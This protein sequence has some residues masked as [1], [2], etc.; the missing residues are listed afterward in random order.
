M[1]TLISLLVVLLA[2]C[3]GGAAESPNA[4][5]MALGKPVLLVPNPSY[6]ETTDAGDAAQLTDGRFTENPIWFKKSSVG[7]VY[8]FPRAV[9]DLGKIEPIQSIAAYAAGG[10]KAGVKFPAEITFYVSDDNRSFHEVARL[11]PAGLKEDGRTAVTH[12]FS[13]ENLKTRGRYVLVSAKANGSMVFWDEIE[14]RRGAFDPREANFT[15]VVQDR[16]T[17]VFEGLEMRKD[18][19]TRGHFP[20]TPH[21][22]WSIPLAGGSVKAI[23]MNFADGMRDVVE[24]A[25][26]LDL[27][28]TPVPHWS[29]YRPSPLQSLAVERITKAL[30]DS[31]VMVVG[32]VRWQDFPEELLQKIKMRVR[33]GMGLVCVS[34]GND[35][36]LN[37]IR[38][39]FTE[40]P[41]PGDQGVTDHVPMNLIPGYHPPA[42]DSHFRLSIFGKGRVALVNPSHFTRPAHTILPRFELADYVDDTNGPL[43]YYFL[44][45]NKLILWAAQREGA[46]RLETITASPEILSVKVSPGAAPAKLEVVTRDTFF[47]P[48]GTQKTEVPAHGGV[49]QFPMPESTVGVHPVDVWLRDADGKILETGSTSFTKKGGARITGIAP[50]K[51]LWMEGKPVEG[52]IQVAEASPDTMLRLSLFDTDNRL[53]APVQ[54]I[55][56]AGKTQVPFHIPYKSPQTLAA[57][58]F[59][60]I[61]EGDTVRDRR[62]IRLWVDV[63]PKDD[64]TF[65]GWYA[66]TYQPGA[67]YCMRLLRSLG[68]DGYVSLATRQRAE[69]GAYGNVPLGPEDIAFVR[70][71]GEDVGVLTPPHEKRTMEK[72]GRLA[73]EW[74]PFGVIHWSLG[75]E[76]TLGREDTAPGPELLAEFQKNLQQQFHTIENLNHAWN[77]RYDAWDKIVPPKLAE[78]KSGASLPTWIA[79]RRF[80][81]S[82]F[83]DYHA[84]ARAIITERIPRAVVGLSG[85]QEPDSFNGH[86]WW[87]LTGAVNH[88]SGYVGVQPALQ[89]SF[90]R[91]GTFSTTFLGYDYTDQDEQAARGRP[92]DLLFN[93]ANG[94][95][96]YTL[97]ADSM[98]CP[99]ILSD[100]SMT[101]KGA[102]FFEE[103]EVLKRGIGKLFMEAK[104]A[105]DGIAIHYSPTSLHVATA[106]GLFQLKDARRNFWINVACLTDILR[107]S[108]YQFDFLHEDQMARGDLAKYKV[109]FLPWSS[110]ISEGEAHAIRQFVESG[111]TVI[112]DSFCGIRDGNGVE[113]PML[114]DLFGIRQ[115][116]TPPTPAPGAIEITAGPMA[117]GEIIPVTKG[118]RG[119]QLHG[120]EACAT[121]GGEPALI[122]HR[123][124]KGRT[125]FLNAGFSD[126]AWKIAGGMAGEIQI[127]G[128]SAT[129][130]LASVQGFFRKLLAEAG[131]ASPIKITAD[132]EKASEVRLSRFAL[133]D[134]TLLGVLRSLG[135]GP[136]NADD[137]L[138]TQLRFPAAHVY[139]SRAGQYL[140]KTDSIAVSLLRGVAKAY[141]LLPYKVDAV[142]L[143][144]LQPFIQPGQVGVF[145]FGVKAAGAPMG[146]HVFHVT[147]QDPSGRTRPEYAGNHRAK[148]GERKFSIPFAF[149]DP[150]GEWRIT[151][152]DVATGLSSVAAIT[153]EDKK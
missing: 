63:P 7:W 140:G 3:G 19:Y 34:N 37:P 17:L 107:D 94:I 76:Q 35:E 11:T 106:S 51:P 88:I 148:N 139:D 143:R 123:I 109:L 44:A 77:T 29:Y 21:V 2:L 74:R 78:V 27:D 83:A 24:V 20:E 30:P 62:M 72:L 89:R 25:Q 6:P 95:N 65:L 129:D 15:T 149:N 75:D 31:R 85:T 110:A 52:T 153:L 144:P 55:S 117:T 131:V 59:V 119:L 56:T 23:L 46:R 124:G 45:F 43:E 1:R 112:A 136:V 120:G 60:E 138:P 68:V 134:I 86:D 133:E 64:F 114:D 10:G 105:N 32:A 108:H 125:I 18:S 87:K 101:K 81:E 61:R 90:A 121:V 96:Y 98:N 22:A 73:K 5:N 142:T 151:A 50:S 66:L 79:F 57:K 28:Y 150:L 111:G 42:G 33:E 104:Y 103:L 54:D 12:A 115:P 70:P 49:F 38:E 58:L 40:K 122:V 48:L 4:E 82:R 118:V 36:W 135:F 126:Y 152:T 132:Y 71:S 80:M 26:R 93:G 8:A 127:G 91:P 67:E 14:V 147:A 100:L 53:V 99:L 146:T 113:H 69:N 9:I 97:V 39:L 102:W 116:L 137:F 84:K 41:L 130:A 92:W 128:E 141:A 16:D 145:Q 47:Q 13:A